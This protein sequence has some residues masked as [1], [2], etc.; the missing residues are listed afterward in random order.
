MN[1][2]K[3]GLHF[4]VWIILT[5]SLSAYPQMQSLHGDEIY[6]YNGLHSGNQI[7]TTFYNDGMIGNRQDIN[8]DDI[9]GEWPINSGHGY[10]NQLVMFVGSEVED[11]NGELKHI[12]SE[13]NGIV[14]GNPGHTY[15]E[16][17]GD[18]GPMGEW[19]TWAPLPGFANE[20]PPEED[21]DAP[22]IAMSQWDWSWPGTWPDKF[23]DTVDPGWPGSWNGYFGKNIQNADQESYYVMDDYNNREFAFY[24]D[25]LDRNRRGLGLRTTVRGFQ[26]SNVLV[27]DCLFFLY[28]VKNIATH[29]HDKMNFGML[30]GP[31]M[32]AHTNQAGDGQ[33]DGGEYSLE[34]DLGYHLDQDDVGDG[35]W[36]PVG[37]H[38]LAF[39]ETPGNPY[40]GIDNDN[41]GKNGAGSIITEDM[42]T[43]KMIN[44]GD[45]IVVIN[46][47][48][49]V[50]KVMSMP[51]EGIEVKYLG[52]SV[53]FKPGELFEEIE[54]NLI[55]D[56]LNGLIDE[57]NG[58]VFGEG[59][60]A[61]KRFLYLGLK[62]V[63]YFTGN[64]LDNPLIDEERDDGIDNDGDWDVNFDDVGLDGVA[65]TGDFGEGDGQ[66]TSGRGTDL[67]GEPRID[68]TDIDESDMIGLTAFNIF[69]PWTIYPLSDDE[70][71]WGAIK[72]GFLNAIG[73]FGDTDILMGSGYFPLVSEQIERFS[74]GVMFGTDKEDLLRNKSY[75]LRAYSENYNFAKA[76][77]IPR[78]TAGP[79]DN[80]VT[81]Y[82]D[83]IAEFSRDPITGEDFEGYRIYRSTDPGFNDMK[84]I[85]DMFGSVSYRQPLVQFDLANG[86][87]GKAIHDV[88][89]VHFWLGEDTGIRHSWVDTTAKNGYQ[90]YYAITSY[91]QGSDSLGIPPTECSKY[92][93]IKPDGSVDKG[94]NVVIV[95]PEAPAAGFVESDFE[96][97]Q[98]L[99]GSSATGEIQVEIIDHIAIKN[100]T[101]QV[102]FE[103]TL[104]EERLQIVLQTKNFTLT[105]ITNLSHPIVLIDRSAEF[106]P[107]AEFPVMDG[108][109]IRALNDET[110][111]DEEKSGWSRENIYNYIFRVFRSS[112]ITGLAKPCDYRI[113]FGEP[114]INNS[115]EWDNYPAIEVNFRVYNV[116]EDREIAFA[117]DE[118]DGTDG[119]FSGF[120]D[121]SRTDKIIFLEKNEKDSLIV[122]WSMNLSQAGADSLTTNPLPGDE[123]NIVML[124]PF[125]SRD[126]FQFTLKA[127]T[128]NA[129]QAKADLNLIRVVPNPY[130]VSNSWEPLNPYTSGRGPRELHFINL[131]PK[132]NIKIFNIRGQLV[133]TIEHDEPIWNGTEIWNMQTKDR[134]DIAYGVYIYH[135][136]AH[137]LGHRIGKFA[138]IK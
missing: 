56:N 97:A 33:D 130:V 69:T 1:R 9:R 42:F 125:L 61:I 136:E 41:D 137:E 92:I 85:T 14:T 31:I 111:V 65:F 21:T 107:E 62:C 34:E 7:R 112:K 10:I 123:L 47:S 118:K 82:W 29:N 128:V 83:D 122:T 134:L 25:S 91:D 133:Q 11:E 2:L 119:V 17:S 66:P 55:D 77:Y 67:P 93:S 58:S 68:K 94:T 38:G 88:N 24:P 106:G 32:G 59:D 12:V 113:F 53:F 84:P 135:V 117:L 98:W 20:N 70:G 45:P 74:L 37:L 48:T 52:K 18:A 104:I 95:R 5:I 50:R 127:Q 26:W 109:R 90:Y 108:F 40:D 27:E 110:L 35:G 105:D 100:S 132:C 39:F 57:N 15:G 81:L 71:L 16:A 44:D 89:G 8:P 30:S 80:Q 13:G 138:I 101:Y 49:F 102:T 43:P 19:W 78:L 121:K 87:T 75:A 51:A 76:P 63:D 126:V 36:V 99:S 114:G 28:D 4:T 86:I 22:H 6:S 79:G 64:G 60:A 23:D 124:K 73:Q 54:N 3:I 131:P 116:S 103:D 115:T 129:E 96:K 72:P 46:Y 120:T